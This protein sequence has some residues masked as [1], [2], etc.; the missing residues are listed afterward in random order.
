MCSSD[1]L[2]V[3]VYNAYN[4]KNPYFLRTGRASNG[5]L[6]GKTISLLPTVPYLNYRFRF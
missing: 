6:Q 2:K 3:G 1:L 5:A 4:R